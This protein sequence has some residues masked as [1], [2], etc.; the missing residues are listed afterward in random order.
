MLIKEYRRLQQIFIKNHT[1]ESMDYLYRRGFIDDIIREFGIGYNDKYDVFNMPEFIN[2]ITI[3]TYDMF[4][5][6]VS[7]YCRSIDKDRK[8]GHMNSHNFPNIYF[9]GKMFYNLEKVLKNFYNR[10]V[11]IFEGQI[12]CLSA[13][14]SGIKNSIAIGCNSPTI[15]QLEILYRYFDK[16]IFILDADEAGDNVL[17]FLDKKTDKF[18]DIRK[19]FRELE[20]YKVKVNLEGCKDINDIQKKGINVRHYIKENKEKIEV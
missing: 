16:I 12:D 3:P 6:V 17:G 4:G 19:K 14:Q 13:C 18:K 11:F 2:C 7:F 10:K 8:I 1:Q 9:K 15:F 5:R 20:L